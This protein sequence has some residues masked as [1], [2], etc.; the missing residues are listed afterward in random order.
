MW[1][2]MQ[3]FYSETWSKTQAGSK[4][5]QTAMAR[6]K[7]ECSEQTGSIGSKRDPRSKTKRDNPSTRAIVQ[8]RNN[9]CPNGETKGYIQDTQARIG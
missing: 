3:G 5:Q 9:H 6:D 2:H 8:M 7:E 1:I 4:H